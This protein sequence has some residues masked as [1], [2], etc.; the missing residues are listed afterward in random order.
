[1]KNA[2]YTSLALHTLIFVL[3][4]ITLPEIKTKRNNYIPIEIIVEEE[5]DDKIKEETVKNLPKEILAKNTEKSNNKTSL[6]RENH[7]K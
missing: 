3:I 5:D 6:P 7:L 2:V 4:S 1:M